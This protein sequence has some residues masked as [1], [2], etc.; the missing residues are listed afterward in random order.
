MKL[1]KREVEGLEV[2]AKSY[3]AWDAEVK[4]FGVRKV[5]RPIS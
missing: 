4:G 1:T 5:G 2:K 3:F